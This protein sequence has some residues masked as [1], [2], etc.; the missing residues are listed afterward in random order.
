MNGEGI[1]LIVFGVA[2]F[3][4]LGLTAI[5][6]ERV[7]SL[8]QT[9]SSLSQRVDSGGAEVQGIFRDVHAIGGAELSS[10]PAH[11]GEH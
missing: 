2:I 8:S 9:A 6:L 1:L 7:S 3:L 10:N 5:M 11:I 4:C